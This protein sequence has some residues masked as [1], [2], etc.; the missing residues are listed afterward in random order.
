MSARGNSHKK[1]HK[2]QR[3][4]VIFSYFGDAVFLPSAHNDPAQGQYNRLIKKREQARTNMFRALGHNSKRFRYWEGVFEATY[5]CE[6]CRATE[7]HE[8]R[9]YHTEMEEPPDH[10]LC[11]DHARQ[12]GFCA[13]CGEFHRGEYGFNFRGD[14]LCDYCRD[15]LRESSPAGTFLGPYDLAVYYPPMRLGS[16]CTECEGAGTVE[17][18][19]Y[20]PSATET[21]LCGWCAGAGMF[22]EVKL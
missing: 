6:V 17:V 14:G 11:W 21:I 4:D 9:F 16:R 7:A 2:A 18:S 13:F 20:I 15:E 1:A 3:A 10:V 22:T 19:Q 5:R 8:C 12:F